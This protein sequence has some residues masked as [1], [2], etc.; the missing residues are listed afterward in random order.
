[1]A[2]KSINIR[3]GFDMAAFR[4]SSQNLTKSLRATG[5]EMEAIGKSMSMA[6]TAPIAGLA[7]LAVF[8]F[9]K[10][11]KSVA[12]VEA[13]LKSTG[14][15]VGFVSKELQ[16]MASALQSNSLF[17]DEDILKNV[18]AQLLTFTNITGKAFEGAQQVVL[19]YA[20]RTGRDLMGTSVMIGK[21]LNDPIAGLSALGKAGVQFTDDQKAVIKSLVEGGDAAKAQAIILKE[22]E[23]QYG[24]SAAAAAA[25]G[26]GPMQQLKNSIMD[27]TE[28]FGQIIVEALNPFIGKLKELTERFNS[29]NPETKK[30]IAVA[31]AITA[32]IGPLIFAIGALN[33]ALAFLV[34]N[35]VVAVI[36][37]LGVAFV[38]LEI[39]ASESVKIFADVQK[40]VDVAKEAYQKMGEEI[41]KI[42]GLK[43]KG[44]SAS[45]DEI[46]ATILSTKATLENVNALIKEGIERKKLLLARKNEALD[47]A[48]EASKGMDKGGNV[49]RG[50]NLA[51]QLERNIALITAEIEN[52][53]RRAGTAVDGLVDLE[54]QLETLGQ[55][56]GVSRT[57]D[58][59]THSVEKLKISINE[60]KGQDLLDK[61]APVVKKIKIPT[62]KPIDLK[63]HL[64]KST[65]SQAAID[66]V[67]GIKTAGIEAK[68]T[69]IQIGEEIGKS[70]T[71]SLSNFAADGLAQFGEMLGSVMSGSDMTAEDFGRGLLDSI[72]NFMVQLGGQML[73]IGIANAKLGIAIAA[74]P[75]G[76]PLA[77]KAGA[78]LI[79]A[80]SAMAAINKAGIKGSAPPPS[81][82]GGGGGGNF[83]SQMGQMDSM[84]LETR[85]SGRDLILVT[86]RQNAFTR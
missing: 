10:Q 70:I 37:A 23:T 51:K 48:V 31:L 78:A 77:I 4:T 42:N 63:V 13:G 67:N 60:I 22:L 50:V 52:L 84:M 55:K 20:S 8:N 86:E 36:V 54:N 69:A 25:A 38:A 17:G 68:I 76:A 21:A 44:T 35:P 34:A 74:G 75:A 18:T 46:A 11:A 49:A 32:A 3:A 15:A 80:G 29:L 16:D 85:I 28:A 24:G 65:M 6:L 39:A 33:T 12:Q 1:M 83:G 45:R 7:A 62:I 14:G 56:S 47:S 2:K 9:D 27:T 41:D 82:A 79:I 30:I 59:V 5:K 66:L 71:H 58:G 72:A 43:S 81:T 40:A 64:N 53:E 61:F 26:M 57:I 19:D 73:A